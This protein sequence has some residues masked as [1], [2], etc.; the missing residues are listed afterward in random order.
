[1]LRAVGPSPGRRWQH[2]CR[3]G[4]VRQRVPAGGGPYAC[5]CCGYL[6]LDE[7][8]GSEIC[9]VCFWEDDGRRDRRTRNRRSDRPCRAASRRA[10]ASRSATTCAAP[11]TPST[12]RHSV[13]AT[14]RPWR[15]ATSRTSGAV[16]RC[17]RSVR[18]RCRRSA[19]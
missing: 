12:V 11:T 8:G 18:P 4:I 19:W 6:T 14:I 3:G 17:R 9:P 1:M 2:S 5:P 15:P 7:R 13:A 16:R 10:A